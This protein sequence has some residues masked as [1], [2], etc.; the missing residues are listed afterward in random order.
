MKEWVFVYFPVLFL[1]ILIWF[2]LCHALF[3]GLKSGHPDKYK[4]MGSPRLFLNSGASE[5][6]FLIR[7]LF[8]REWEGLGDQ[9][10]TKIGKSMRFLMV[11][12]IVVLVFG[13]ALIFWESRHALGF[14]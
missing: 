8:K 7:F 11:I 5:T 3:S 4:K 13:L 9:R 14:V 6:F 12:Y 2:F 1:L 10:I